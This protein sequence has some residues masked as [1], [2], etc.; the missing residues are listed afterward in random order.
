M[1]NYM[2]QGDVILKEIKKLP[3]GLKKTSGNVLAEGESTGHF[4]SLCS[5]EQAFGRYEKVQGLTYYKDEKGNSYVHVEQE[6]DLLHQ[7][8]NKISVAPGIYEIGIVREYDHFAE[9]ARN[10]VD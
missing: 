1:M 4:H 5:K 6:L 8:H 2:Q 10:V 7:E 3:D 9:E